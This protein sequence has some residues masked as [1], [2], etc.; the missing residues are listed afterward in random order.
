MRIPLNLSTHSDGLERLFKVASEQLL[1]WCGRRAAD[2]VF[3]RRYLSSAPPLIS[4]DD[5]RASLRA[6][7]R[8]GT[9]IVQMNDRQVASQVTHDFIVGDQ[10]GAERSDRM[11]FSERC[12]RFDLGSSS[13]RPLVRRMAFTNYSAALRTPLRRDANSRLRMCRPPIGGHIPYNSITS[14][15][16][17]G[18]YPCIQRFS[19]AP[20]VLLLLGISRTL[21]PCRLVSHLVRAHNA[22]LRCQ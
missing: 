13:P 18:S 2:S 3:S 9:R 1:Q 10:F 14:R 22:D 5:K 4:I 12:T 6:M 7:I 16:N 15:C 17:V 11:A 19:F 20:C 21:A 8:Q